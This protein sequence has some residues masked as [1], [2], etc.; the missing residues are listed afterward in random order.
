M[1]TYQFGSPPVGSGAS[2]N[3][4]ARMPL[5]PRPNSSTVIGCARK[6]VVASTETKPNNTKALVGGFIKQYL[7][8]AFVREGGRRRR[9]KADR[10]HQ[11]AFRRSRSCGR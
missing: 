9:E 7:K 8:G 4:N 6:T 11:H 5:V 3:G 10:N 2:V 1:S